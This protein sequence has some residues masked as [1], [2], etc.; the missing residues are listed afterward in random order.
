M[1]LPVTVYRSD[2]AGAPQFTEGM[3]PSELINVLKKCL[4][5]GYGSKAAAG[6][7]VAFEDA[8]NNQIVFRNSTSLASGGFVKFWPR[9]AGDVIKGVVNFQ[10][11]PFLTSINPDWITTNAVGWRCQTG[12]G[13]YTK[14]WVVIATAASFYIFSYGDA[15]KNTVQ[16]STSHYTSFFCGDLHSL[17]PNDAARFITMLY[18]SEF[19]ASLTATPQWS[20]GLTYILDTHKVC[21][22]HQT[23]GSDFPKQMQLM[24]PFPLSRT[25]PV[26]EVPPANHSQTLMPVLLRQT[27]YSPQSSGGLYEDSQGVNGNM[28]M[29]HPAVRGALPGLFQSAFTGYTDQILPV[30]KDFN[31]STHYLVP[32]SHLGGSNMWISLGDWYV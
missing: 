14:N 32:N 3:K 28:S 23:D 17:V 20:E 19:D 27:Y 18:P 8:P 30:T 6:W 26:R 11:A 15:P 9:S 21:K 16:L 5:T 12:A 29:L 24:L 10:A 2:D 4:V 22:M 25:T 31:G 7:S 1:G 13:N